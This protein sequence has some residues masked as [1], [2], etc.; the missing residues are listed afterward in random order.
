MHADLKWRVAVVRPRIG[1]AVIRG[2]LLFRTWETE[3]SKGVAVNSAHLSIIPNQFC[4]ETG[5]FCLPFERVEGGC[6]QIANIVLS[7]IT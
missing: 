1:R 2:S 7:L 5:C 6:F 4:F 3:T